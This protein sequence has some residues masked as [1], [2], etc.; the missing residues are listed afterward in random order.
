MQ[1]YMPVYYQ[2][3]HAADDPAGRVPLHVQVVG[4]GGGRTEPCVHQLYL[5]RLQLL[6]LV[7][8]VRVLALPLRLV[9]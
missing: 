6:L 7:H 9:C 4:A 5:L 8:R 2:E 3:R 1:S